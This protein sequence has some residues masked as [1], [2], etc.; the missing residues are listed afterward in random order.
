MDAGGPWEPQGIPPSSALVQRLQ[1]EGTVRA[2]ERDFPVRSQAPGRVQMAKTQRWELGWGW[3]WDGAGIGMEPPWSP[4]APARPAQPGTRVAP[5]GTVTLPHP[6][7]LLRPAGGTPL[8]SRLSPSF[9]EASPS[10]RAGRKGA[11]ATVQ[12]G[13]ASNQ[14]LHHIRQIWGSGSD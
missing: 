4:R 3:S 11:R 7:S 10:R 2:S 8:S 13:V 14:D 6:E 9:P 12:P 1:L 5:R